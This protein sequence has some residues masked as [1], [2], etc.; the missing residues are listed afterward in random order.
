MKSKFN[1]AFMYIFLILVSIICIFPFIWMLISTTNLSKDITLGKMTIG[2]ELLNNF[3]RLSEMVDLKQ[4]LFN[5]SKIAIIVTIVAIVVCSMAGYGFEM[6]RSKYKN[7]LFILLL[8]SMMLPFSAM[9]IPLFKMFS[10]MGLLNTHIAV[11]IPG[12]A[13]AF[14]IFFFRQSNKTFPRE[15]MEAARIDGLNEVQIFFKVYMPSMK[16]TFSAAAIITFMASWNGF[17]WP[18]IVLQ[19]P[20]KK[21]L[22]L[23]ISSLSSA[24]QP[25][26]GVIMAAILI[27]VIPTVLIF[28]LLQKNFVE[29]MVGSVK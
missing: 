28:F 1:K 10:K 25:D 20:D 23:V 13:T 17:L 11:I 26:Y 3:R 16:S 22:P 5:S 12:I 21:T 9:M 8:V 29:G 24:Y 6:Y 18:L 27:S 7:Y 15:L 4:V 14:L 19:S 2:A